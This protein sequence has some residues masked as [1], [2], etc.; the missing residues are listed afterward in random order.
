MTGTL[1]MDPTAPQPGKTQRAFLPLNN[2]CMELR[3]V[4][5]AQVLERCFRHYHK[6]N[7]KLYRRTSH[8]SG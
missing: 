1:R 8:T 4:R 7:H 3:K 5:S 2:K 6:Q